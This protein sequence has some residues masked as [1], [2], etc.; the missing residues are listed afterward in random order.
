MPA[1]LH[2]ESES[3]GLSSLVLTLV[4]VDG[5][6]VPT[7]K[8]LVIPKPKKVELELSR[9]PI[10]NESGASDFPTAARQQKYSG[11]GSLTLV[12]CPSRL[13]E[14]MYGGRL[15]TIAP[16]TAAIFGSLLDN[17]GATSTD[18]TFSAVSGGTVTARY[19]TAEVIDDT[20]DIVR[21]T[22]VGS[23]KTIV[24]NI[25]LGSSPV[26]IGNTG[27]SVA[28]GSSVT[29]NE[30]DTYTMQVTPPNKGGYEVEL[31]GDSKDVY[32]QIRAFGKQATD[33]G[34]ANKELFVAQALLNG[35]SQM[36]ED[37]VM[38][39]S[40]VSIGFTAVDTGSDKVISVR[41]VN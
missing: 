17:A 6:P 18:M 32:V 30:G 21:I 31:T 26:A 1:N 9:E 15:T 5:N 20:N 10:K 39:E 7:E 40:E 11:A 27:I 29:L 41:R 23:G 14:I 4:D 35:G 24:R 12:E 2:P 38:N 37:N 22:V 28:I 19:I 34:Y 33:T 36:L 8:P 3:F 13:E 25:T 16:V